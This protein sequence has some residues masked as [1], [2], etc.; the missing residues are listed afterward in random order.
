MKVCTPLISWHNRE[1]VSAIDFQPT[2]HPKATKDGGTRLATG[3]DDNHVVIWELT[4]DES[5]KVEPQCVCDLSRHQN[6]VNAVRWSGNGQILA[7]ADTDSAIFLWT[8]TES[9]AAPDIFGGQDDEESEMTNRENWT[10]WKT[11]RGHLQDIVGLSWSPCA[12][13]LISCSTDSTAIVFDVNKGAKVKMLDDHKGWVNGVAWD[14]QDKYVASIASDRVLRTYNTKNY[15]VPTKTYKCKLPVPVTVKKPETE[16]TSSVIE[17]RNVRLFHDDTFQSFYRRLEFSPDGELLVV[18]SGVLE[19]E[20]EANTRH[21]T[22]VF[23]RTNFSKPVMYLPAKEFS[24]AV[25]FSPVKYNLRPVPREATSVES[26]EDKPWTKYETLFCLPYRMVYAVATQNTIMFYDTQQPEPF[27]RISKIHY[28]SLNDMTW[29]ADG[30]TL[31]IASTDGYCSIV[32]F[33]PGD[34]GTVFEP[35]DE[36][37]TMETNEEEADVQK[38]KDGIPLNKEGVASPAEIKIRSL[39]EGGR[40]NPKRLQLITL[41]SPK[42]KSSK[43]DEDDDEEELMLGCSPAKDCGGGELKNVSKPMEQLKLN[44]TSGAAA[45]AAEV[46][47]KRVPLIPVSKTNNKETRSD[48]NV[49]PS[50]GGRRVA[51]VT[52]TTTPSKKSSSSNT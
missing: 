2:A 1:R 48:E 38:S 45:A 12:R 51:L 37:A 28:I 23:S 30:N 36:E 15:R 32:N 39:K 10:V 46:Q 47:K 42:S 7:S 33:R 24:V 26:S 34:L 29:S 18:P 6:S 43:G 25:R 17:E 13:F 27:A 4:V 40:P 49:T 9:E 21:C 16:E 5:G 20:G 11:L 3:G 35:R 22:Y 50:K 52:L 19:I 31:V 44:S 41:S 8:F 14:P